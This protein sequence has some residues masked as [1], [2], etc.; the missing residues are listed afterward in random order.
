MTEHKTSEENEIYNLALN[1]EVKLSFSSKNWQERFDEKFQMKF[2]SALGEEDGYIQLK[3]FIAS[4]VEEAREEGHEQLKEYSAGMELVV[5][6]IRQAEQN[7]IIAIIDG[8]VKTVEAGS[9][10]QDYHAAFD[11][12]QAL[13][14]LKDKIGE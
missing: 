6:G 11:Y 5:A 7:R 2:V 4:V 13:Q 8:M 12:N 9:P 14:A 1:R 3:S 10:I